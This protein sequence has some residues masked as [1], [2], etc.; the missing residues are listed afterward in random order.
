MMEV[1]LLIIIL[2]F[3]VFCSG[4]FSA[5]EIA[6]F[7]L[8]STKIKAY[9]TNADLSKRLIASLVL[10]PRDLLVTVFMLNTMVN[11]LLQNVAS[12][13]FGFSASWVLKIGVPLILT[14][15]F[16]EIIP[17]Y[18]G[19]QNNVALA[20]RVAPSINFLQYALT[21][22][23]KLIISITE[24]V[25]RI[26]FF[27]LKKEKSISKE[28]LQ[29]V[30]KTSQEHGVLHPDEAELVR[31]YLNLQEYNCKE[32]MRPREDML[33]YDINEPLSKLTYLFVDQEVSRIPICDKTI[34]N[35]IGIVTSKQFFL[36]KNT[37]TSSN[38]LR[39][40]AGKPYYIPETLLAR[41]LLRRFE[42]IQQEIAIVVDEYGSISGLITKE[43]LV[44]LVIGEITDLRDQKHLYMKAKENE[45]IAS[46][47]FELTEF[48]EIF[49]TE[50]I[51]H[52]NMVTIGGWLT[53]QLGDIP[54][55]GTTFETANFFFQV[56][57]AEPNK[58]Q[59]IYIRKKNSK[60]Q[61]QKTKP[62]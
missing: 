1:S 6:L 30:L 42:E 18:I 26:M 44:E 12:S 23:R 13:M 29:H 62:K 10:Q 3:L 53:E 50:L 19:L 35:I 25:S 28:E 5:S 32:L 54:K 33:F 61:N 37:I 31:G 8:P 16:G 49:D 14:L 55:S 52:N 48:N 17:K 41:T 45:I 51:S 34:E 58:I 7:S 22:V 47:R 21:P 36:E 40:I 59:R 4:F 11:I 15:I 56:L 43:D 57:S 24:P 20:T 27:Y 9:K 2:I 60:S 46:G 39:K 38:D